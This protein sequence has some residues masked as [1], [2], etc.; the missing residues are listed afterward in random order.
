MLNHT[1]A[2]KMC[3]EELWNIFQQMKSEGW[4][5]PND[6]KWDSKVKLQIIEIGSTGI[7]HGW[8]DED[9]E[10]YV[11]DETDVCHSYPA[12]VREVS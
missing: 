7:H 2:V 3:V 4:K 9:G 8:R 5:L 1:A 12:F 11:S 6:A 10:F